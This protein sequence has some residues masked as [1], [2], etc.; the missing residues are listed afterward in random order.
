MRFSGKSTPGRAPTLNPNFFL[1]FVSRA[2]TLLFRSSS[3]YNNKYACAFKSRSCRSLVVLFSY[4]PVRNVEKEW[5]AYAYKTIIIKTRATF[6][7]ARIIRRPRYFLNKKKTRIVS[8]EFVTSYECNYDYFVFPTQLNVSRPGGMTTDRLSSS[9]VHR[10][11]FLNFSSRIPYK[12]VYS[13]LNSTGPRARPMV[14]MR[15]CSGQ[16]F[17]PTSVW[18]KKIFF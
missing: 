13:P 17:R 1:F 6:V 16:P 2:E 18:S 3:P 4:E 14:C 15:Q 10:A 7:I 8:S 11:Y 12:R 9:Y 5:K